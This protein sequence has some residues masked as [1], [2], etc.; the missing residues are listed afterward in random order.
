MCLIDDLLKALEQISAGQQFASENT[1]RQKQF[2]IVAWM[3]VS[4]NAK[5]LLC[6][7]LY[8]LTNQLTVPLRTIWII[9]RCQMAL[10]CAIKVEDH[11][12]HSV[13]TQLWVFVMHPFPRLQLDLIHV[14]VFFFHWSWLAGLFGAYVLN[15]FSVDE[16]ERSTTQRAFSSHG[17]NGLGLHELCGAT[18]IAH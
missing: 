2:Y 7:L 11:W 3:Y 9:F 14:N 8:Q 6:S 17:S 10:T 4:A 5:Y 13:S 16:E 15:I 1:M 18:D 12:H